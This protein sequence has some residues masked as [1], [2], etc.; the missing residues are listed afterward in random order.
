MPQIEANWQ[1]PNDLSRPFEVTYAC[2]CTRSIRMRPSLAESI[3]KQRGGMTSPESC[4]VCR[5]VWKEENC[6]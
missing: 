1:N 3:K 5:G 4:P 6:Q 2:G